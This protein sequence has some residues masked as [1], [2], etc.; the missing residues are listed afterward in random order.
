MSAAC[1]VHT[2]VWV[3]AGARRNS[4]RTSRRAALERVRDPAGCGSL[5]AVF[6]EMRNT[7]GDAA[8]EAEPEDDDSSEPR[9]Q[10]LL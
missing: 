5:N 6:P 2:G 7:A 8:P 1:Q 3:L 4:L 10:Q 9:F